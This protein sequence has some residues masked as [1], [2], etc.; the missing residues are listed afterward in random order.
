MRFSATPG[1]SRATVAYAALAAGLFAVATQ[2]RA[3]ATL[4][5]LDFWPAAVSADGSV[6]VGIPNGINTEAMRWTAQGGAV[7]LGFDVG[8]VPRAISA[9]GSI[10][11]LGEGSW[12][13]RVIRWSTSDGAR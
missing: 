13:G 1:H 6:V 9:D 7:P 5:R 2:A 12:D 8:Y 10:V 11:V 3:W 4:Q